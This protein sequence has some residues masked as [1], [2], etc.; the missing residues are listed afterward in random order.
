MAA[1]LLLAK[2]YGLAFVLGTLGILMRK[3]HLK[4]VVD[5]FTKSLALAYMAGMAM[6][7]LGLVLVL[8]HNVWGTFPEVLVSLLNW[9]ILVKG[10]LY[11]LFPK[12]LMGWAKKKYEAMQGMWTFFVVLMLAA[13]VYLGYVGFFM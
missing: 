7:A 8:K 2:V 11:L 9:I 4:E 10:A 13:G 6:V 3:G 5:D 1:T 12:E